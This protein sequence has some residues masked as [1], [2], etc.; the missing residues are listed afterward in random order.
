MPKPQ[1]NPEW[2]V[3][4]EIARILGAPTISPDLY[5]DKIKLVVEYDSSEFHSGEA[6]GE[7]DARKRN[8]YQV[9]G[10]Q[11][12]TV[13]RGQFNDLSALT[14]IFEGIS[15]RFGKRQRD[16]SERQLAKRIQLHQFLAFGARRERT[17]RW[18]NYGKVPLFQRDVKRVITLPDG[19][20]RS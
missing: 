8:A 19:L 13:T 17:V 15:R 4:N 20:F 14:G 12:V 3:S 2:D 9:L 18:P 6:P 11:V 7:H 1:L 5:W 16:A 10:L